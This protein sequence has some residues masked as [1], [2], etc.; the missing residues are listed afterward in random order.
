MMEGLAMINLMIEGTT[1]QV[2]LVH[3]NNRLNCKQNEP[4]LATP[5]ISYW[6]IFWKRHSHVLDA[7]TGV[8]QAI[9]LKEWSTYQNFDRMY[10]LDYSF[11]GEAQLL[12]KLDDP[13]WMNVAGDQ[14]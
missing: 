9:C 3:L 14:V 7:D 10:T 2:K 6:H 4:G 12:S 13:V 8:S 1:H 5:G 11:M